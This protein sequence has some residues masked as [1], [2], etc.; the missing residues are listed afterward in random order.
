MTIFITKSEG[1]KCKDV[2][3]ND[4]DRPNEYKWSLDTLLQ[5]YWLY[6][7]QFNLIIDL[8]DFFKEFTYIRKLYWK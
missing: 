2:T 3:M 6:N 8:H 5:Y 7:E 4:A 1:P